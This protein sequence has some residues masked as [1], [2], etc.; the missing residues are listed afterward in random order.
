MFVSGTGAHSR[1]REFL[2]ITSVILAPQRVKAQPHPDVPRAGPASATVEP[3]RY[4]KEPYIFERYSVA[5]RFENDGTEERELS[6]RVRIQSGAGAK[7][8]AQLAFRFISPNEQVSL[9]SV[10]IRKPNG[11]ATNVLALQS[12]RPEITSPLQQ[13]FPAYTELAELRVAVPGLRPRDTLEYD[14][15]TRVI[16]PFAPGEFWFSY[17]FP[18]DAVVLDDR[19]ELNLPQGRVFRIEAPGFVRLGGVQKPSAPASRGPAGFAFT[20]TEAR[21][22]TILHW[23]GANLKPAAAGEERDVPAESPDIQVSSFPN[24]AAVARWYAQIEQAN[25]RATPLIQSKVQALIHGSARGEERARL[26]CAYVSQQIRDLD[27]ADDFG[28]LPPRAAEE[29]LTSGYGDSEEKNAL[30]AAMLSAAGIP[31]NPVLIAYRHKLDRDFPSPS[32]FDHVVTS[33]REGHQTVWIDPSAAVAP[34][35]FLPAA[36]RGESALRVAAGVTGKIVE[37]P[38]NPPFSSTQNVEIDAHIS[39]LGKLSGTIRY[40]FRGDTEYLLRS[41]FHRAPRAQWN[42]LAQTILTLDGLTGQATNVTTSDPLDT[43]KPF[44]LTLAFSDPTSFSWPM[45]RAKIALPLLTIGMPDAPGKR[46]QPVRLGTPLDVE[47]QLRLSF[48]RD[49]TVGPPVGTSVSRDYADFKSSYRL[50]DGELLASRALHFKMRELPAWRLPD[51]LAF[52]RAVQADESQALLLE[53]PARTK[54]EI[55]ADATAEDLFDAGTAALK[56]GNARGAV[57]LL[58]RATELQP[59]HPQGW[60]DL[61]LA[62]L[63]AHRF[64]DAAAAF[65]KQ[66]QL[67]PSDDR[68]HDYLGVALEELH[69]DNDAA[70]AF[71]QQIELQPLDPVAHAQ[72]GSILLRQERYSDAVPELEKAA[73]LSPHNAELQIMLGRAYL[74]VGDNDKALVSFRKA[75]Q[76]SPSPAIRNEAAYALAQQGADLDLAQQ[77]ADAA[78]RAT[79]PLLNQADLAHAAA[80]DLVETSNLGAYWDTLGWVYFKKGDLAG[81]QRYLQAAW[82]L[83]ENGEAGDHLAQLYAK[84]G[85]KERAIQ[86]CALALASSHPVPDTRARL[87]LLLG[88]NAQVDDLV[89]KAR[90][91][92]QK[93]SRLALKLPVKKE[94]SADFLIALS[95]GGKAGGPARVD[96]VQFVSGDGLLGSYAEDLKSLDYGQVFPDATP[97]KLIRRGRLTCSAAGAC[98]FTVVPADT[99][100]PN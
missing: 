80:A 84:A 11:S 37:T 38:L 42:Q 13:R 90:A 6:A 94:T 65:Q 46:G 96:A 92:L 15:I 14:V 52:V 95:P 93:M 75:T 54:A 27:L 91:E 70:E 17:E 73:I 87:I 53:N 35:G 43:E 48:P 51:Y 61:G 66:E 86:Q 5:V 18:R 81:A 50:Q 85:E 88:G 68:T 45:K 58:K 33:V 10:R 28:R 62:Y 56:S 23:K 36:L 59:N 49:F 55:P 8:F 63:Q 89:G 57:L 26:L 7:R 24:W 1:F 34:F 16:K 77:Y 25:S 3:Q 9:R 41:A 64:A 83:K 20:R 71:H 31:A 22:R 19:L 98:H 99:A 44:Q 82:R 72:L 100:A 30:L 47:T 39:E 4:A 2:L 78:I 67:T 60:N 79:A 12:A 74:A 69:R 21:G 76:L 29:V 97:L 32:Q 40:A